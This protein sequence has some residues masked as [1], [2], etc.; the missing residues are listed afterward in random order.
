M[1]YKTCENETFTYEHME[2]ETKSANGY[3]SKNWIEVSDF[4]KLP[5]SMKI[6]HDEMLGFK[7]A[8][9][10]KSETFNMFPTRSFEP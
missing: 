4:L 10:L 7:P 3:K 8:A 5:S 9:I 2:N 1:E 6:S